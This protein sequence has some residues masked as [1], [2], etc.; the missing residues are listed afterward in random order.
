MTQARLAATIVLAAGAG[1]RMRSTTPKVLHRVA[2]RTLLDHVL[3]AAAPLGAEHTVVVIG[4][5]RDAVAAS[6]DGRPGTR[7]V[8]QERQG[9]TGH[10]VRVALGTLDGLRPSDQVAVL[11]GDTPLLTST[12]LSALLTP[13]VERNAA[14][15]VLTAVVPDPTGYGRIVRDAADGSVRAIVEQRDASEAVAAIREVNAGVYVFTVGALRAALG[16]LTTDN[17][18]GEEYLTDVIG[19]LVSDGAAVAA[20][21][22]PDA[23]ETAGVN[24]R[25]QLAAA[26]A[27]LRDRLAR[28]AML[29]GTT[30]VDPS[31]TWIDADVTFEPDSTVLPN[32]HLRG[33]THL[34]AG[35]VVGPDCTLTDTVVGAGA[36][37]ERST[38]AGSRIGPGASVGPYAHL[39]PGTRLGTDGRIG[40]Y[41]ETKAADIGAGTKVPHLA[42]VGDA[43][44]G[45]R[46]NI[47]CGTVFANYDGVHKHRTVVGSDVKIGSDTVLVA[48]VVVGDGAYT[49]AGAVVRADVPPGALAITE[50]RQRTVEGWVERSRPGSAAAT[51]ARRAHEI[52]ATNEVHEPFDP[53]TVN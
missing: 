15:S 53:L 43:T 16:R 7:T 1:T 27:A 32:T 12:T 40:A 52:S 3:A 45:E 39:R 34:A 8:V 9:G 41:V 30:V 36:T 2:G 24:D 25:V 28:A 20:H 23:G 35:S 18:Q 5:G 21:V 49:G 51:A 11:P 26:G 46:S 4:H 50:G 33:R 6:L 17:A 31:S 47:G 38:A 19:L 48:P 10:A 42:Y 14:A 22:A 13:H 37:V 29:A 44:I